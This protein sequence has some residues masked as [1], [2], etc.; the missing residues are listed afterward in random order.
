MYRI[1]HAAIIALIFA[2]MA[3]AVF[4]LQGVLY[5]AP[6]PLCTVDRGL[7]LLVALVS[8]ASLIHNPHGTFLWI[9]T[10]LSSLFALMGIAVGMRHIWLQNLPADQVPECGPDLAYM[11]EVFPMM[12]VIK[13]LFTGAGQCAEISW[14]FYDITLPQQTL[15]LFV[16]L[17]LMII[18][19]HR[20]QVRASSKQ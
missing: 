11:L 2:A 18:Y 4:Y 16:A 7:F 10:G 13:R 20:Q 17:L 12:D 14:T 15:L 5:L 3:F 19:A 9:Y 6:C 8:M 1:T